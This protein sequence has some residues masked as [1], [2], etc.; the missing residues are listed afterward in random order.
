M[1]KVIYISIFVLLIVGV[2]AGAVFY[3]NRIRGNKPPVNGNNIITENNDNNEE[4][5]CWE[6]VEMI[7]NLDQGE[8]TKN[9][10][11]VTFDYPKGWSTF[12]DSQPE[13]AFLYNATSTDEIER[14]EGADT[15]SDITISLNDN[16]EKKSL[17]DF[18]NNHANGWYSIYQEKKNAAIDGQSAILV[19]D[20]KSY[21]PHQ[22]EL[23]AFIEKDNQIL[24]VTGDY[25]VKS[26]FDA[27]LDS[28]KFK[29]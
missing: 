29:R 24:I 27:V 9:G 23:A 2:S 1:K 21:I 4:D 12:A 7:K 14:G 19:D 17:S 20:S 11:T 13:S 28:I 22:P 18:F 6:G 8:I 26:E 16:T 15:G 10:I 25:W 5:D 3:K